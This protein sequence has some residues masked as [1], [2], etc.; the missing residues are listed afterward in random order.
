MKWS[1]IE[2][3]I[4]SWLFVV[5]LISC[6]CILLMLV[7]VGIADLANWLYADAYKSLRIAGVLLSF[8]IGIIFIQWV[9]SL[10]SLTHRSWKKLRK[11]LRK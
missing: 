7:I 10:V 2:D 11:K 9:I 3:K 5:S 8:A 6:F 4:V 1:K